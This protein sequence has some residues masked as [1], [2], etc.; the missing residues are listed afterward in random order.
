M[1]KRIHLEVDERERRLAMEFCKHHGFTIENTEGTSDIKP[2]V[3]GMKGKE[4]DV[5]RLEEVLH[6]AEEKLRAQRADEAK[7][8]KHNSHR[9][10]LSKVKD[11]AD[12]IF[13]GA[14]EGDAGGMDGDFVAFDFGDN[15][16]PVA[17]D[18]VNYNHK[19]RRKLNRA[20]IAAQ[21]KKENLVRAKTLAYCKEK[22]LDIPEEFTASHRPCKLLNRRMLINGTIETAKQERVR[23]RVETAKYN[24]LARAFR[25]TCKASQRE[26]EV[27][28]QQAILEKYKAERLEKGLPID[29]LETNPPWA[30]HHSEKSKRVLR[31]KKKQ[32]AMKGGK[33]K[34]SDSDDS[35]SDDS[36]DSADSDSPKKS[37]KPSASKKSDSSKKRARSEST[38]EESAGEAKKVK[39]SEPALKSS[40]RESSSSGSS[41]EQAEKKK[42]KKSVRIADPPAVVL[43]IEP[44]VPEVQADAEE[45]TEK[46]AKAEK[47]AKKDKKE[48]KDKKAK[49][50]AKEEEPTSITNDWNADALDGDAARK[51]KFLRLLGGKKDGAAAS[52]K[53]KPEKKDTKDISKVQT[54]LE[55]QF[56][57][58]IKLKHG[59]GGQGKRR[60]IGA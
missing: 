38:G 35:S 48:K 31:E 55:R 43:E 11:E 10:D 16:E 30:E 5:D 52:A 41:S 8:G 2:R 28:A 45:E 56:E 26:A 49:T 14:G 13:V 47:K 54:E 22:G 58:G 19:M 37:E 3:L 25:K 29:D 4:L 9:V 40:L 46:P 44:A 7:Y 34:G 23:R 20:I 53:S 12:T 39:L 21:I 42:S 33:K 59:D 18:D 32:Q 51:D 60:G 27:K 24:E 1:N 50:L 36:D 6:A 15:D 57:Q 17:D